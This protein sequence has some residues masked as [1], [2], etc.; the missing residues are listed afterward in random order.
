MAQ[1]SIQERA[2][3]VVDDPHGLWRHPFGPVLRFTYIDFESGVQETVDSGWADTL[4]IGRAEPFKT[5]IGLASKEIQ[6]NFTFQN[7]GGDLETEV[8]L[9]ARFLDALKYP[10]YSVQQ[11][12]SYAP[13]T[14]IL[15]IGTLFIGR[16]ILSSGSP[17]WKAPVDPDTLLPHT[18]EFSATFSV[19][20]RF[21]PDLSYRFDGEWQ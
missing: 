11:E 12:I 1:G 6:V 4:P 10:L 8:L 14:C 21:Q 15:K 7:F 18:C 3:L 20:R 16:V 19:V 9:P 5:F 2:Y 13:P 17:T